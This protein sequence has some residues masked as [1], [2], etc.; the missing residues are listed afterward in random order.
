MKCY[1]LFKIMFS[2]NEKTHDIIFTTWENT[3][4]L[5]QSEKKQDIKLQEDYSCVFICTHTYT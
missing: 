4:N 1:A 3:H 2:D 5:M